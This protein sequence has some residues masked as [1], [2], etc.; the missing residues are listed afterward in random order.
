MDREV[1]GS[2]VL[3]TIPSTEFGHIADG[4]YIIVGWYN[5]KE[6]VKNNLLKSVEEYFKL[7]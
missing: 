5:E 3:G 7:F 1:S 4:Q 2:L 6:T